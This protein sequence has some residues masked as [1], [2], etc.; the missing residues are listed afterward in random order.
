MTERRAFSVAILARHAGRVLLVRHRRLGM[1]LPV[2]GELEAGE[3]P[4]EAAR[5]ELREE[6]GLEGTFSQIGGS[7]I[8]GVDG[9]PPGLL[10]YEEHHAGSKGLHLNFCFLADVATD[11]VRS[12]GEFDAFEWVTDTSGVEAPANVAQ[13]V[14]LALAPDLTALA[15]RWLSCFNGRDLDGLLALYAEDAVHV[16]PKL[17]DRHPETRG[18]IRGKASLRTWWADAMQRL[19]DLRYEARQLVA[20]GEC[21]FMDYDR[22]VPGEPVLRV[23][24]SLHVRGGVIVA[25][26]V[27]HG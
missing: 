1:W 8:G 19:P 11:T 4:L 25:S 15:R 10:G 22:I 27:F 3:T 18:E 23:A 21:V 12:N 9:S 6:T 13:L 7:P 20:S 24:E 17:R 26:H 14:A 16:S 2:G 5:R